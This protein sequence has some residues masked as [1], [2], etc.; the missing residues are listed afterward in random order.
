MNQYSWHIESTIFNKLFILSSILQTARED[1]TTEE[2]EQ[3]NMA[4]AGARALWSLSDSRHNKEL[5]RK[6]GIVPLM[7]RLLKSCHIDVVIPIMGTIQKCAS[8]VTLILLIFV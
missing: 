1:L 7:A 5:M 3:L 2:L 4:R 8:Q 6:S